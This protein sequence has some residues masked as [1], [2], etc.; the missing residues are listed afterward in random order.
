M[1]IFKENSFLWDASDEMKIVFYGMQ[2]MRCGGSLYVTESWCWWAE[3]WACLDLPSILLDEGLALDNNFSFNV[4]SCSHIKDRRQLKVKLGGSF[5]WCMEKWIRRIRML[6]ALTWAFQD[7]SMLKS[8]I[9]LKGN[10]TDSTI[11]N[12]G[13]AGDM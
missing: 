6:W 9:E 2:V 7:W 4:L 5:A 8:I 3:S 12:S 1:K 13:E 10:F 11:L